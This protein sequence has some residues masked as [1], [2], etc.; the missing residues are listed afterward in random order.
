MRLWIVPLWITSI[1]L[2]TF[3]GWWFAKNEQEIA[4]KAPIV[5]KIRKY[6]KYTYD[7]L[8]ERTYTPS[9]IIIGEVIKKEN[10]Y[11]SYVFSFNSDGKRVTG[12]VNIPTRPDPAEGFPAIVMFRGF[13]PKEGYKTGTGTRNAASVF[14]KEGFLTIAPDFLGYGGSDPQS[15]DALES[16]F[17][18]YIV[19]LN[20]LASLKTLENI[21][22]DNLFIWG[23]SNGGHLAISLLEMTGREIPAALWAP[24]TK[25][26]PYSIL[27]YT[28]EY[29]DLGKEL[30]K[31]L[32]DFE[33][34]Y[35]VNLYSLH[36]YLDRI[37]API[38]LH[39]GTLD[40]EVLRF[41]SDEFVR[42]L[43]EKEK[44]ITYFVYPGANHNLTPGWDT[45]IARDLAFFRKHLKP[46]LAK[47]E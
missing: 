32:A 15:E 10:G 24:L 46:I 47:P 17:D 26:F 11:T 43:K 30:R 9:N 34:D 21:N 5:E 36:A 4:L 41:W 42:T 12:Q 29:D 14:A 39:Q 23:H 27:F 20:L 37:N 44:K 45:V 40:Q 31:I 18:N 13:A 3:G 35:D 38:Q 8:S 16:R 7:N 25:P 28:D 6:D 33:K 2:A 1:A 22:Q 19:A